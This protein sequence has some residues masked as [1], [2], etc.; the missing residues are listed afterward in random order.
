MLATTE[1]KNVIIS[2]QSDGTLT[3]Q[4]YRK[5]IYTDQYLHVHSHHHRVQKSLILKTRVTQAIQS[6]N[7]HLLEKEKS[8]LSRTH[9]AN[10]YR[11]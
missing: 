3:H 8:H 6:Y 10:D 1:D 9:V 5:K 7:S 2:P 4:V 11:S